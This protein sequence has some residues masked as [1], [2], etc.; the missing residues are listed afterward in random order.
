MP[1]WKQ[2]VLFFNK[3]HSLQELCLVK[4]TLKDS[5]NN[6]TIQKDS[7]GVSCFAFLTVETA[8]VLPLFLFAMINILSLF[9]MFESYGSRLAKLHQAGR[10][11]AV[12]AYAQEADSQDA[13]IPDA[14]LLNADSQEKDIELVSAEYVEPII[15]IMGYPGCLVVSGCIMHKWIGYDLTGSEATG[16]TAEEMVYLTENGSVYHTSRSCSYLNPNVE[17]VSANQAALMKNGE[18]ENYTPCRICGGQSVI[19]YIT[20]DGNRYHSSIT[21]GGLKRTV[22]CVTK[23]RAREMGKHACSRCGG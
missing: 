23:T 22:D 10:Q 1:L 21:C 4:K 13:A 9:L 12:L 14:P 18:G 3:K 16:T 5:L 11:L 15:G 20:G 6:P 2:I 19:V 7:K 17:S 8:L